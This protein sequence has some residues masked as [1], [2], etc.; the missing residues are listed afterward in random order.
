MLQDSAS[1]IAPSK[2][3][4]PGS[5]KMI[6]RTGEA[7]GII[8]ED[9]F[10]RTRVPLDQRGVPET[11]THRG[12][13]SPLRVK[14]AALY[15]RKP[16]AGPSPL[17]IG[18]AVRG[19]AGCGLGHCAED[20]LVQILAIAGGQRLAFGEPEGPQSAGLPFRPQEQGG[21]GLLQVETVREVKEV[22]NENSPDT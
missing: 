9:R 4:K 12:G 14:S 3:S 10:R 18:P 8:S 15:D 19:C 5:P 11:E 17:L 22:G 1:A 2:T 6:A 16:A 21:V 13:Q 7:S 20:A